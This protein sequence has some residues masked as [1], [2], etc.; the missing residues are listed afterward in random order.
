MLEMNSMIHT[1][2][3]NSTLRD[4]DV[5]TLDGNPFG[6]NGKKLPLLGT[7]KGAEYSVG[8]EDT[9]DD[10]PFVSHDGTKSGTLI[11][12]SEGANNCTTDVVFDGD[13]DR[14]LIGAQICTVNCDILG[15]NY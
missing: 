10:N 1:G 11:C 15:S 7:S 14:T 3:F 5:R 8:V 4:T 9:L 2:I 13:L 12:T 6:L